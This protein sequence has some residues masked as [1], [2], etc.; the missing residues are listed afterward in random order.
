MATVTGF[1][2]SKMLEIENAAIVAGGVVLDDLILTRHDGTSFNAGNVRGPK[3]DTGDTG[4]AGKWNPY[5]CTIAGVTLGSSWVTSEYS[6]VGDTVNVAIRLS[7]GTGFSFG[8]SPVFSMPVS[9]A[10]TIANGSVSLLDNGVGIYPG[11]FSVF[12]ANYVQIMA[13]TPATG[14]ATYITNTAP[15]AWAA[16][17]MLMFSLTYHAV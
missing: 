16:G 13:I 14:L 9:S 7:L 8:A 10:N 17:D 11:H 6:R 12:S 5:T 1:T 2:A 4:N 3:G 15:F